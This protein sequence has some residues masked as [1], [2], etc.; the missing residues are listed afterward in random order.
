MEAFITGQIFKGLSEG[1]ILKV[2]SYALIFIFLWLELRAV[3]KGLTEIKK[4]IV[5]SHGLIRREQKQVI[6]RLE[7]VERHLP[8]DKC[9]F[10]RHNF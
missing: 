6:I 8:D 1:D 2:I 5:K 3:K 4:E 7:K 9:E 10:A